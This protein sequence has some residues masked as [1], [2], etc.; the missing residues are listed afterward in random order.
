M[1]ELFIKRFQYYKELA[2]KTFDQ[3]SEEQLF[4]KYNEESN[5]IATLAKHLSGNMLS[6]WTDFRTEDGE[7]PNRN[8]DAEFEND[9]NSKAEM[10]TVWEKGWTVF[11]GALNQIKEENWNDTI[12]IRGEQLSILDAVLRQFA[13]HPYHIGQI[14]Y[15]GK[16]L[17]NTNWKT[18]SIAKNESEKFNSEKLKSLDSPEIQENSSPVCF[19]KSD[20]IRDDYKI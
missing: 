15:L 12:L 4:W 11:F 1:K 17:T 2:E 16:M 9:I 3:V 7:K 20:E 14:V 8:R 5:S 19:A 13:H 18:L 10:L 6:R